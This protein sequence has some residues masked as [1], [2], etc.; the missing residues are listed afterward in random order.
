[1]ASILDKIVTAKRLE[2]EQAK[3]RVPVRDV[4]AAADDAPRVRAFGQALA[5]AGPIKLIAEIKK[6]SPSRG[7]ICPDFR[8]LEVAEV[9]QQSGATCIS[10]L[11]DPGFFQ[12][13]LDILHAVRQRVDL[14]V[15]RK[16]FVLD[17]YQVCEARAAGADAV[18]LIAE[19]LEDDALRRLYEAIEELGMTAL[20]ECHEQA[21]LPRILELGAAVIG[22]NN[23]NLHTFATDL[24][25][26][27][28][29][30]SQ[31]PT[32]RIVVGESGIRSRADVVRLENAGVN[33]ILVG[34]HLM[35]ARDMAGAVRELLGR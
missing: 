11:T 5:A 19:C 9:Y 3:S 22:I 2:I 25:Q 6:A 32:D 15:L 17:T 8:P 1:V 7:V 20:V 31:V 24:E 18:L 35:A 26:T 13:S 30:R 4:R 12:G 34:E 33:A 29:L 27:I 10:V 21:N 14:P 23:R 28:R 16:D